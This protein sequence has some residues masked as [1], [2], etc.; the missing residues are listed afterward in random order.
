MRVLIPGI[1]GRM[2]KVLCEAADAHPQLELAGGT[3]RPGS[4]FVGQDAGALV[5]GR[6]VGAPIEDQLSALDSAG[7]G[8][9]DFTT[10][11]L[12]AANL[13]FCKQQGIPMVIGTTGLDVDAKALIAETAK[14]TSIVFAPN[15]SVG[16]NVMQRLIRLAAELVGEHSD[17]EVIE[18]H[19]RHKKDAPSGTA[20]R[21]GEVLA[22]AMGWTL[23]D[24]AVYGREGITG[25]RPHQQIGFETIRAGDVFGDHTVLF[26]ADGERIEITHKASSRMTFAKGAV[27]ALAWLKD[28]PAGLYS[29]DDVLGL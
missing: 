2:G 17:I 25:E 19:H 9:I 29:M 10:P 27:R 26:A 4:S 5:L 7:A 24:V 13:A 1:M 28:R 23:E 14:R 3:V 21:L 16:V 22:D 6:A 15:M 12:L 20:V 11:D 8:L 18:A